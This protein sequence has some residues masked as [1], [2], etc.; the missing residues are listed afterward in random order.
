MSYFPRKDSVP[1]I[2]HPLTDEHGKIIYQNYL[3]SGQERSRSEPS[4]RPPNA[5][6][7]E[8]EELR[9]SAD[10]S[11]FQQEI[12]KSKINWSIGSPEARTKAVKAAAE[13]ANTKQKKKYKWK[14]QED[15]RDRPSTSSASLP[16]CSDHP[17]VPPPPP[18]LP[19]FDSDSDE[20][21]SS[22]IPQANKSTG[23]VKMADQNQINPLARVMAEVGPNAEMVAAVAGCAQVPA[24]PEGFVSRFPA[25]ETPVV[26]ANTVPTGRILSAALFQGVFSA[27]AD[28]NGLIF[29]TSNT[30]RDGGPNGLHISQNVMGLL[31]LAT[32]YYN[33]VPRAPNTEALTYAHV[34][35]IFGTLPTGMRCNEEDSNRLLRTFFQTLKRDLVA[36]VG[37]APPA[38]PAYLTAIRECFT[39]EGFLLLAN[40]F[41]ENPAAM[42]TALVNLM[43]DSLTTESFSIGFRTLEAAELAMLIAGIARKGQVQE[44]Y[45]MRIRDTLRQSSGLQVNIDALRI[46]FYGR[47]GG[48]AIGNNSAIARAI[49]E[50]W[51][52]VTQNVDQ[53]LRINLIAQQAISSFMTPLICFT[54]ARHS[55]PQFPWGT[56]EEIAGGGEIAAIGNALRIIASDPYYGYRQNASAIAATKYPTL[57]YAGIRICELVD[58]Q[59]SLRDY[60][61]ARG[62]NKKVKGVQAIDSMIAAYRGRL[63]EIHNECDMNITA[64]VAAAYQSVQQMGGAPA[65]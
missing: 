61:G 4:I 40:S 58:G 9:S 20:S 15:P 65:V 7:Q 47:I 52:S 43:L 1:D 57:G 18:P 46:R 64:V 30:V 12:L 22:F 31:A 49:F 42:D 27:G 16:S 28:I 59:I 33:T 45:V 10:K 24:V 63:P 23:L 56:V 25:I 54:L 8:L 35:L 5:W 51:I 36:A 3:K 38:A 2:R 19:S 21:I 44:R 39:P 32:G 34:D 17:S 50:R 13:R 60:Q 37:E 14:I 53:A 48:M 55:H 11:Y 26:P 41:A 29:A 62:G 6:D